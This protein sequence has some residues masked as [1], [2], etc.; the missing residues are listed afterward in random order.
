MT[1]SFLSQSASNVE[2]VSISWHHNVLT[3]T[4]SRPSKFYQILPQ[5]GRTPMGDRRRIPSH[6]RQ[7]PRR[8]GPSCHHTPCPTGCH[9]KLPRDPRVRRYHQP[10]G[11][12]EVWWL[13]SLMSS[14]DA[15]GRY[16]FASTS[17]PVMVCFLAAPSHYLN[18]T[19]GVSW[20]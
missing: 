4:W 19:K 16:R 3:G 9:G 8:H 13:N 18:L 7:R 5:S 11:C 20:H 14:N 12:L 2:S 6:G 1:S 10:I 17:A 15:I